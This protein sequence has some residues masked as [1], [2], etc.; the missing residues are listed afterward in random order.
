MKNAVPTQSKRTNPS[1]FGRTRNSKIDLCV[2]YNNVHIKKG[3]EWKT[4]FHTRYGTFEYL[5]MPFRLTNT[6]ATFQHFMN[7]VF[8][9][10]V[11]FFVVV[12]LDDILIYS[13]TMAEHVEHVRCVLQWLRDYQLHANPMKL[14]FHL[15]SIEY[16]GFIVSPSGISM[17]LVKVEAILN[18]P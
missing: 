9:D 7:N 17:D 3:D 2:G 15:D 18:W 8:A 6:L 11:D 13:I 4:A 10:M 14:S 5:V 12:Y 1:F 16:L